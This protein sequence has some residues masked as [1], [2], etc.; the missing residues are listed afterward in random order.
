MIDRIK[1]IYSKKYGHG[2]IFIY[3]LF[4]FPS[5]FLIERIVT[6]DYYIIHC[7]LDDKIP[8]CEYFVVPYL[9]WFPFMFAVLI[10]EFLNSRKEFEKMCICLMI[11]MTLFIIVS[12]VWHN[13][14]DLRNQ[15]VHRDNIFSAMVDMLH[16]ADTPTNVFPSIHVYNTIVCLI[17]VLTAEGLKGKKWTKLGAFVLSVLIILSTLFLKQHSVIDAVAGAVLAAII[18]PIVYSNK[19]LRATPSE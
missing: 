18:C 15:I 5:F 14:V 12:L 19:I 17:A 8:F 2:L 9:L 13:G 11:G 6:S 4:Y 3:L 7:G 16:D 1:E 10:Y